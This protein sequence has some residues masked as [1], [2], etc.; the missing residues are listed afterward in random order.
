MESGEAVYMVFKVPLRREAR[1]VHDTPT[2]SVSEGD[3]ILNLQATLHGLELEIEGADAL[4]LQSSAGSVLE[5]I[6][7]TSSNDKKATP[8]TQLKFTRK[9][10]APDE[11]IRE[12]QRS[13]NSPPFQAFAQSGKVEYRSEPF[14]IGE[15]DRW[16]ALAARELEPNIGLSQSLRDWRN[17]QAEDM[18]QTAQR[19]VGWL[20]W[21]SAYVPHITWKDVDYYWSSDGLQFFLIPQPIIDHL[22]VVA[23]LRP[24][25]DI[26]A[27][28]VNQPDDEL[29]EPFAHGLFRG[30]W[31]HR[32][33]DARSALVLGAAA[34]E[35]GFKQWASLLAPDAR[36]LLENV[37][38]PPIEKMLSSYLPE[39]LHAKL[40]IVLTSR[41]GR[42]MVVKAVIEGISARNK[43][44]H[45]APSDPD[46]ARVYSYIALSG[47]DKLT[48]FLLSV[49][50]LLWILDH[51]WLRFKGWDAERPLGQVRTQSLES[52]R[53]VDPSIEGNAD[54][55]E[56]T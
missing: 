12:F 23:A 31:R 25:A 21:R 41:I 15:E 39:I 19:Y 36:W 27:T 46:Y 52:W 5:L 33:G 14:Q 4:V 18:F 56:G 28:F 51:Y 8:S 37:Q 13:V 3:L 6:P 34:M 16:R 26:E 1:F 7:G 24:I 42:E 38:A 53:V 22:E 32:Y 48:E 50:D 49:A 40:G 9:H 10:H 47:S 11:V 45:S 35:V 43:L 29:S 44:I 54:R 30:A 2:M 17:Q 20:A 55:A